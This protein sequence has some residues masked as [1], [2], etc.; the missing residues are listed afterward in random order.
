MGFPRQEYWS[1]LPFS[2]PGA[3]HNPGIELTSL[4][5]PALTGDF[6]ATA[7]PGKA[8]TWSRGRQ[9][10]SGNDSGHKENLNTEI[11]ATLNHIDININI[12][13]F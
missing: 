13:T 5:S 4:V 6:F 8:K 1:G 7:L 12:A 9:K 10:M 11:S 3:L 2:Y